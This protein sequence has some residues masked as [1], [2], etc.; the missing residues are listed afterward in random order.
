VGRFFKIKLRKTALFSRVVAVIR[1]IVMRFCSASLSL[2][3]TEY[4]E[5]NIFDENMFFKQD[6]SEALLFANLK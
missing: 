2:S 3:K 1:S 5:N 4:N 6:W